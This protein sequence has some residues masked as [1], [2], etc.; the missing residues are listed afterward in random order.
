MRL[1]Y[2]AVFARYWRDA[3]SGWRGGALMARRAQINRDLRALG[4]AGLDSPFVMSQPPPGQSY[5][6]HHLVAR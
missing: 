3:R 6:M 2:L 1:L 4:H 5:H